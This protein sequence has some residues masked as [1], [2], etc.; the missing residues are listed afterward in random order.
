MRLLPDLSGLSLTLLV[1]P[2]FEHVLHVL[3]TPTKAFLVVAY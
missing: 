2:S 3:R 1:H